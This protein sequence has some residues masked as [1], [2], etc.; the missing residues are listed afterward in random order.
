MSTKTFYAPVD[1]PEYKYT[2]ITYRDGRP[3]YQLNQRI[4]KVIQCGNTRTGYA[5]VKWRQQVAEHVNASTA[6]TAGIQRLEWRAPQ[7]T[8][9]F[10]TRES[11]PPWVWQDCT[12]THSGRDPEGG[13]VPDVV[14]V[15]SPSGPSEATAN[16]QAVT[17]LYKKL[18]KVHS[19][20]EGGVFLGELHKTLN[21]I[22]RPAL[23]LR[24]GVLDYLKRMP[25]RLR[26]VKKA[27]LRETI[28]GTYL[29][30]TFGWQPLLSDIRDGAIALARL[31]YEIPQE[32]FRVIGSA[33]KQLQ[34]LTRSTVIGSQTLH[35]D[36]LVLEKE[37]VRVIYYGAYSVK[38]QAYMASP[39]LQRVVDLS[40]FSLSN[41]VPTMWELIPK[42]FLVDY[43]VN[44]GDLL[45]AATTD[46]SNVS[47]IT[48]VVLR[49]RTVFT[50]YAPNTQATCAW[51]DA[52]PHL[53]PTVAYGSPGWSV[54]S[55][56]YIWRTPTTVPFLA[57]T[58]QLP[59]WDSK[60]MLNIAALLAGSRSDRRFA[61]AIG[62]R[63]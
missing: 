34:P 42:S 54:S 47:W 50:Y 8:A 1:V 7:Q 57:P 30:V 49:E 36:K 16:N 35:W 20:F 55:L 9:I 14:P 4:Q 5:N 22:A 21:M 10:S 6:Y 40:G 32:R 28:A 23:A 11:G 53:Y 48:K 33:E 37:V 27:R 43:F 51:Y 38:A 19:Q 52:G 18:R 2:Y 41:F 45:M 29:E 26:G 15:F 58:F 44:I 63:T 59:G 31:G 12:Q 46:T 3:P 17:A 25:K 56:R 61:T 60:H 13:F 24:Q 62:P 39:S